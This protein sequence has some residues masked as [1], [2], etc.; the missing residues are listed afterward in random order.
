[1]SANSTVI[2]FLMCVVINTAAAQTISLEKG[3]RFADPS[4]LRQMELR[5]DS[6]RNV[7]HQLPNDTLKV[8]ALLAF[9]DAVSYISFDSA[10]QCFEHSLDLSRSLQYA[11]GEISSQWQIGTVYQDLT[12]YAQ[13]IHH[14]TIAYELAERYELQKEIEDGYERTLN[15]F[16]YLGHF[17]EAMKL[18][19]R[20]LAMAEQLRNKK[21]EAHYLSLIG[22]IYLRQSHVD[23]AK[24]I[25]EQYLSIG[26]TTGDSIIV[27]DAYNSLAEVYTVMKDHSTALQFLF[28]SL[29]LYNYLYSTKQFWKAD[30]LAYINFKIGQ[31]YKSQ[32]KFNDALKYCLIALD[33]TKRTSSNKYD[34][35]SYFN[36]TGDIY[37]ELGDLTNAVRYLR[38]GLSL[39]KEIKHNENL[40]DA[41]GFMAQTF[42]AK[43]MFDSAYHYQR[44]YDHLEDSI[45]NE[46][47]KRA[48]EH[49]MTSYTVEKK[50][51]EILAL[52]Q[53]KQI[54]EANLK[55]QQFFWNV[56]A[57]FMVLLL[58]L[59]YLVYNRYRLKQKNK[60][61][62]ELN[63]Q[64]NQMFN[65]IANF[66]DQERKRIA[67]DIHDSVGSILSTA[68]L[69]L[70]GIDTATLQM[71]LHQK[72]QYSSV[73]YLLDEAVSELRNISH[74]I[75]PAALSRLGLT[76]ALQNLFD[77][78]KGVSA[79][80]VQF[81]VYGLN[82][83]LEESIE[84]MVYR[85]VLELVNNVVKHAQAKTVTV[86]LIE[87]P[88]HINIAVEDDG[89][90]FTLDK[91]KREQKGIGL[92]NI[93]SRIESV[94]GR[95]EIDSHEGQGT[96]ILLD[97]PLKK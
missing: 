49:M 46:R 78:L 63:L 55:Q 52:Q 24:V 7:V 33:Y 8:N 31:V 74:N 89:V 35:A 76:A 71:D 36:L 39:S 60:F 38:R 47:S 66:Q 72:E 79:L 28:R 75:M 1:M 25:Y 80:E 95:I 84:I 56:I 62:T 20:G 64:Q 4:Q 96:S 27:A 12:N 54:N 83:R 30:R 26:K 87:Y 22:F 58:L 3:K 50:D 5:A 85:I 37:R 73:I 19:T 15:L 97:I 91:V 69:K 70:S 32:R 2:S 17:E 23:N 18:S 21:L 86:Q 88:D 81:S 68:K 90:G 92:T 34:I 59:L 42:A 16:F 6:L 82:G 29:A 93:I 53:E 9:G 45:V 13:A 65:T 57:A 43:K 10:L 41:Y 51:R 94:K 14:Y 48:I 44:L 61:Q 40:R 67:Q 11:I 77:R